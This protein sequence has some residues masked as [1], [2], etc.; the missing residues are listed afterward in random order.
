MGWFNHQLD[1]A[2]PEQGPQFLTLLIS[3]WNLIAGAW[4]Q[5]AGVVFK[6]S[7]HLR[8]YPQIIKP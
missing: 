1:E 7:F 5:G 3:T 6:N 4:S 8:S 2:G